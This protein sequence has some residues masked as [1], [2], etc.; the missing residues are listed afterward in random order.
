MTRRFFDSEPAMRKSDLI[1]IRFEYLLLAVMLFHLSRRRLLSQLAAEADVL[2]IDDVGM[3]VADELLGDRTCAAAL[4]AEYASFDRAAN[5]DQ[6]DT[7]ML[8]EAL[9]FNR[10]ERLRHV[11]RQRS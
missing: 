7:V 9:I 1:Q 10:D 4:F 8:V 5:A 6:V 3:H 11:A 2:T